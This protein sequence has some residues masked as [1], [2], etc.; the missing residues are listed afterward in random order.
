M[1]SWTTG[2]VLTWAASDFKEREIDSPRLEAELLLATVLECSRIHLYTGF[3]RPLVQD[4]LAA[5][6][7]MIKRRR[8]GEPSAYLTGSKEFWSLEFEVD[9]RVLVPRPETE[10]LVEAALQRLPE[11]G[12][13]LDLCT[14]SG[15]VAISL[16]SERQNWIVDAVD[17]SK[18]A[19]VVA[20]R[21][22]E[23]HNL[24]DRVRIMEGDLFESIPSSRRYA[25]IVANPPYVQDDAIA[26]LAPEVQN[27]PHLALAGG[28][29]GLDVIRCI[30]EACSTFLEPRG[31]L[32]VEI[33]PRQADELLNHLGPSVFKNKGE[34][35]SDLAG[36]ARIIAWQTEG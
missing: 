22:A 32:L 35:I 10:T 2:K 36:H 7:E 18:D 25:A 23:R 1:V 13:I 5:Y 29:D 11:T 4:E 9:S 27:E 14:G 17:I 26:G 3:D 16:A 12:R 20:R 28:S 19:C 6:R 30:I 31:W 8:N 34:V 21:N 24:S 33:D 15:C